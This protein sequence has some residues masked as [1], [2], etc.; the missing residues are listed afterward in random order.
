[1]NKYK[2][3]TEKG[4][5]Y[6]RE[7][8]IVEAETLQQ[9]LKTIPEKTVIVRA[10]KVQPLYTITF[11]G[12]N[13]RYGIDIQQHAEYIFAESFEEALLKLYSDYEYIDILEW[14]FHYEI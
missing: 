8:T 13:R 5:R 3:I 12:E 4:E 10:I 6:D 9:A 1:M 7:T 2:I 11:T 14:S